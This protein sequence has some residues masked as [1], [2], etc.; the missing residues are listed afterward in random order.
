MGNKLN[1]SVS[2]NRRC[3]LLFCLHGD[4]VGVTFIGLVVLKNLSKNVSNDHRRLSEEFKRKCGH[5]CEGKQ[6]VPCVAI[7][8]FISSPHPSIPQ[9]KVFPEEI[10]KMSEET[11]NRVIKYMEQTNGRDKISRS[12]GAQGGGFKGVCWRF[13]IRLLQYGSRFLAWWFVNNQRKDLA[14]KF[15]KLESANSTARK[16]VSDVCL[17]CVCTCV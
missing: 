2:I 3:P 6:I 11:L 4:F 9:H 15:T 12:V 13:S 1:G 5:I 8:S 17:H 7:S 14:E 16:L 10:N